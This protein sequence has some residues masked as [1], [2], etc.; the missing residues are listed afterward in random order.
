CR[1]GVCGKSF[2]G[3]AG[4]AKHQKLHAEEKPYKCGDCGKG[5]NWNSHL[6]RH[7]RIHTG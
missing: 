6:E 4:L 3:S 2:P 5:F 7:R 1:C